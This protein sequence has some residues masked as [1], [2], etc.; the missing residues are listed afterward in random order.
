MRCLAAAIALGL[1][2]PAAVQAA[3]IDVQT[4]SGPDGPFGY[5]VYD[6]QSYTGTRT[7]GGAGMLSGGEGDLTD[8]ASNMS[9]GGGYWEWSPY[10]LWYGTSPTLTF[11]LGGHYS[12]DSVTV[13]FIDYP[14]AAVLLP[15]DAWVS[16][17]DDGLSFGTA[18]MR[19][20]SALERS[21]GND[22]TATY[23]VLGSTEAGRYV[24]LTLWSAGA[25]TAVSEVR[26]DGS[27]S[28]VPEP[29][30]ALLMLG[31][32]AGLASWRRRGR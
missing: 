11:D 14:V 15:T 31:G 4:Y 27:P 30:S 28:A 5:Y 21:L 20:F 9:V 17:S 19:S 13:S 6:D 22:Q 10:I 1:A 32:L 23:E 29:T 24:Q 2:S 8:G 26:F 16:F 18:Q 12:V 3:P 25:W 7:G